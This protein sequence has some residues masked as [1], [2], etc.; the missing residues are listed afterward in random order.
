MKTFSR[1][2]FSAG[3]LNLKKTMDSAYPSVFIILGNDDAR[4][5]ERGLQEC[6]N[7]GLWHYMHNRRVSWNGYSIYGYAFVPPTPF[8]LKDWERYDVSRYL[9][10]LCVAPEEGWLIRFSFQ[11]H[12]EATDHSG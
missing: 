9:D 2:L 11:E 1:D 7:R 8:M 10:P 12:F 4:I 3:F 5:E 6:E